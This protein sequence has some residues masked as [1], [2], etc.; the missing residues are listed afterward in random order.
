MRENTDQKKFR[1]WTLF[2]Q[3]WGQLIFRR[4]ANQKL[5]LKN[6]KIPYNKL[7]FVQNPKRKGSILPFNYDEQLP[8]IIFT[9]NP[10]VQGEFITP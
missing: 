8:Y 6:E 10:K 2:T 1:I 3:C 9:Y 4:G 7:Y 5:C